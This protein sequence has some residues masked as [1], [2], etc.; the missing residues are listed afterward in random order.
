MLHPA[1]TP[2]QTEFDLLGLHANEIGATTVQDDL[3]QTPEF[4]ATEP[5]PVPNDHFDQSRY[6]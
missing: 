5:E 3:D 2:P 6:G 1:Q 4:D